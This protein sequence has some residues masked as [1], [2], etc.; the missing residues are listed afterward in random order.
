MKYYPGPEGFHHY[1]TFNAK[2]SHRI[3]ADF[4]RNSIDQ[5]GTIVAHG[6]KF[7]GWA[8]YVQNN[9]LVYHSNN[10]GEQHYLVVSSEELP[11][12]PVIVRFDYDAKEQTGK[13]LINNRHVGTGAI[14]KAA[15]IVEPGVFSIGKSAHTA[16]SDQYDTPFAF[17]GVLKE[18][19]LT[20]PEF[21]RDLAAEA[22][23]ELAAD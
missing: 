20:I 17:S 16:V 11:V 14:L 5:E 6:G 21:V 3:E 22:A 15:A 23:I 19:R 8:L 7:G 1:V 13:L 12:G 9:R 4:Y 18:V 2:L 10:I